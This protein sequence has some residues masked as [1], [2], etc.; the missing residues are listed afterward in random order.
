MKTINIFIAMLII[1]TCV[2]FAQSTELNFSQTKSGEIEN[3]GS[4]SPVFKIKDIR[5]EPFPANP[6]ET[7]NLYFRVDNVGGQAL[8]PKFNLILD[9][10]FSLD[11]SSYE[12]S[13]FTS[14]PSGEKITLNYKVRVDKNAF[15]GD[16]EVGFK[17]FVNSNLYYDY[18]F[19]IIVE[20]VTTD[21][22]VALQ[23]ISNDGI[24]IALSNTGKN[25]A[26]SITVK[27]KDQ[28]DFDLIGANS[29]IIGN[30]NNG[31]Y[32]ILNVLAVPKEERNSDKLKLNLAIDYTDIVGNRRTL[33]KEVDVPLT[34]KTKKELND[35]TTFAVYD[36]TEQ[37]KN[38]PSKFFMYL[39][40]ILVIAIVAVI[41]YYR[42][43]VK[44]KE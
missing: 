41:F 4:S 44:N 9:Y 36:E 43:K 31:D 20:D 21:F 14:I 26:N 15:P 19:D 13:D 30:L 6:G 1:L 3:R 18:Y 25:I 22:D 5:Q 35:L 16:Y 17:A 42:G 38:E 40:L 37:N 12:D 33:N 8:D 28:E 34:T 2:A 39:S 29:Y 23:E 24:A 10:P 11:P 7:V 32:T 27:L